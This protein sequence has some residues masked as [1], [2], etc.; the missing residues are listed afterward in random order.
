MISKKEDGAG[1]K[2]KTFFALYLKLFCKFFIIKKKNYCIISE[3]IN[4]DKVEILLRCHKYLGL[5]SV[6]EFCK[7]QQQNSNL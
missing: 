3:T 7:Q 6:P 1:K 5:G 4:N 2:K